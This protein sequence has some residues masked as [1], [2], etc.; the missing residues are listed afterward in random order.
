MT[1][2]QATQVPGTVALHSNA[3]AYPRR[4]LFR[5]Q[6]QALTVA[7][8]RPVYVLHTFALTVEH[9]RSRPHAPSWEFLDIHPL[10]TH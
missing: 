8:S 5:R 7:M 4:H 3:W 2:K 9:D 10:H 1:M 6:S